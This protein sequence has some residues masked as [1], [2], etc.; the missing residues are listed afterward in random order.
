MGVEEEISPTAGGNVS[1]FKLL[2]NSIDTFQK[3]RIK[4][5]LYSSIPVLSL[6]PK[7]PPNLEYYFEK[8]IC[9]SIFLAVLS[10]F[11]DQK[12]L[13]VQEQITG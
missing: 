9:V 8:N 11:Q 2:W 6:Y 4:L 13:T 12:R 10:S 5:L 1:R 7:A 3:L